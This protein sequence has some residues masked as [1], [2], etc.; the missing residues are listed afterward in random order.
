MRPV[1]ND[2]R[3]DIV[4]AKE[5]GEPVAKIKKWFKVSGSTVS[6]IWNRHKKTG[7]YA[8]TAYTGRK[9]GIPP[10][11][12]GKIRAKVGETPDITLAGLIGAL[13]LGLTVSGLSRRLAGMGLSYKK[14]RSSLTGRTAAT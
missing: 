13:S 9:S 10:E 12:D 5:R 3:A 14:R 1:S 11:T 8:P 6:R 2:K 4:A 7:S